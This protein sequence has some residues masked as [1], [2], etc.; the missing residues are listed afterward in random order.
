MKKAKESIG[1]RADHM[2]KIISE[3]E[4]RKIERIQVEKEK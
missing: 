1:N 2:E 4:N 3:I